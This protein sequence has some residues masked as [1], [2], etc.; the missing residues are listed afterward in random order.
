MGDTQAL[1]AAEP[2]LAEWIRRGQ[3]A[4]IPPQRPR[5]A[6]GKGRRK[7][8]KGQRLERER[9]RKTRKKSNQAKAGEHA[10]HPQRDGC[11]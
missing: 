5:D 11:A 2:P 1:T 6:E 3:P 4:H 7:G 8:R 10:R 9:R